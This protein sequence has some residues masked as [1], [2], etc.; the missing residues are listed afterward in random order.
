MITAENAIDSRYTNL[1][2]SS[3]CLSCGG[4]INHANAQT[5]EVCVDLGSGRGNDVIRL[6]EQVGESG[7]V[8]GIDISEGMIEKAKKNI[9]KFDIK[10]AEILFSS[11]ENLPL[12]S[13]S[14]DLFISNCVINHA[15]DKKAVWSEV[16]RVLKSGGR[17]VVSDIY[18]SAPVPEEYAN[19]PES[20]SECW[21]GS[22]VK[23]EYIDTLIGC[24]FKELAI[25]EESEYYPK[26]KIE[27]ASFTIRGVKQ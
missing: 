12:E 25:L 14:A 18:A 26:G 11:I 5:G 27:V 8:Y 3:C 4:A 7:Y 21:A 16:F 13:D 15:K 24:G 19:D 20:I 2:E 22:I 6:S 9:A 10:N 17:F 1:A 23:D